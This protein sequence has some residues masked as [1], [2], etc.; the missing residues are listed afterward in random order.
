[1]R[2]VFR[3]SASSGPGHALGCRNP[4]AGLPRMYSLTKR[5]RFICLVEYSI[6]NLRLRNDAN[7]S[8]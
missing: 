6:R 7:R 4:R 8:V 3:R 2:L 1:M 5:V